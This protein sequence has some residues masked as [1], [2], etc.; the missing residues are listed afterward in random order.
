MASHD[1]A[2]GQQG[3]KLRRTALN[4]E[5]LGAGITN[6]VMVVMLGRELVM[7]H[8]GV[9]KYCFYKLLPH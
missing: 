9:Q 1:K 6:K 5:N 8:T 4:T 3:L 7:R 2:L